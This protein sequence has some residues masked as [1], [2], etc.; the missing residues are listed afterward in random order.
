MIIFTLPP[1]ASGKTK[2]LH[3]WKME[4]GYQDLF[5][6]LLLDLLEWNLLPHFKKIRILLVRNRSCWI[7]VGY[8]PPRICHTSTSST[9]SLWGGHHSYSFLFI[10]LVIHIYWIVCNLLIFYS[11]GGILYK[12]LCPS[13]FSLNK[14]NWRLCSILICNKATSFFLMGEKYSIVAMCHNLFIQSCNKR[15]FGCFKSFAIIKNT[16]FNNLN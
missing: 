16:A 9:V 15:H 8:L 14:I 10:P 11:N 2:K 12:L 1:P 13:L 6:P 3:V 4:T 5:N 7:V